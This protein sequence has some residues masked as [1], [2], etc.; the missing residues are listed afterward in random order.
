MTVRSISATL[1]SWTNRRVTDNVP[2]F[3]P[4]DLTVKEVHEFHPFS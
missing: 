1:T 4:L 2:I 3:N